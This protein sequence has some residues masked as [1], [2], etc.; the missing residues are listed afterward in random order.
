MTEANTKN[1]YKPVGAVLNAIRILNFL[2]Q[3]SEAQGVTKIAKETQI[4]QST[5]FNILRTLADA[6]FVRFDPASRKYELGI[7]LGPIATR[8]LNPTLNMHAVKQQLRAITKEF[9]ISVSVWRRLGDNR[10]ILTALEQ[11]EAGVRVHLSLGQRVPLLGGAMGRLFA[12][13]GEFSPADVKKRFEAVRW[14]QPI[15]FETFME[16]AEAAKKRGWAIDDGAYI[17]GALNLAVLIPGDTQMVCTGTMFQGQHDKLTQR[18][19]G[20]SLV[21]LAKD[22]ANKPMPE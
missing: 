14:Q 7:G 18:E 22:L 9:N 16:E 12:L 5:C 10:L 6:E 15:N 4:N 11:S 8:A 17:R 20:R 19:I 2:T 21:G 1:N 3:S 13:S